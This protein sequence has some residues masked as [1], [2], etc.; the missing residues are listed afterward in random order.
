MAVTS[1][2]K[3]MRLDPVLSELARGGV[4]D[5]GGTGRDTQPIS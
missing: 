4:E 3:H 1:A 5:A 2:E